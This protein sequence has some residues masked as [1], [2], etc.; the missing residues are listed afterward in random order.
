MNTENIIKGRISNLIV[1]LMLQEANYLTLPY[2]DTSNFLIQSGMS[3]IEKIGKKIRAT[4]SL[5]IM[6]KNNG[7]TFLLHVKYQGIGSRGRNV[8]WGYKQ[9]VEYWPESK[10]ILV[11]SQKPYFLLISETQKGLKALPVI[12]S[13]FLKLDQKLVE[14]YGKVVK[15]FLS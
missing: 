10:L 5:L 1:S 11:R 6:N 15:K 2:N 7:S 14:K 12:E 8:D 3:K 13:D 9:L 4:P